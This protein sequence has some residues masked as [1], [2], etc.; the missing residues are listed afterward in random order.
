MLKWLLT[1]L[2]FWIM[3]CGLVI[4]VHDKVSNFNI[5]I[6]G[7]KTVGIAWTLLTRPTLT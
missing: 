4:T 7:A 1:R 2:A 5:H 3:R 6:I